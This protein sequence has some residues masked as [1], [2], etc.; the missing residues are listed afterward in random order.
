MAIESGF[1]SDVALSAS[2]AQADFEQLEDGS[3]DPGMPSPA[4]R[5]VYFGL[6]N[7]AKKVQ[8]LSSPG[9]DPILIKINSNVPAWAVSSAYS[10]GDIVQPPTP[11]GYKYQSE[12][13]GNSDATE[14]AAWPTTI[15]ATVVDGGVTWR[16]IDEIHEASEIRLASTQAGLDGATPGADLDLGNTVNGGTSR[17]VWMRAAQ[18]T[19]PT[20]NSVYTDLRLDTVD[21]VESA[22]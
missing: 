17:A 5:V 19:H 14:P 2:L 4:D 9:V 12:S 13:D 1:F 10:V 11:N 22:L 8:A 6:P 15:G 3:S 18:G 20:G 7:A 21:L 16:C